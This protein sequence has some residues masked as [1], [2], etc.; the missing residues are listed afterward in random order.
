MCS[1]EN[2]SRTYAKIPLDRTLFID[3]LFF[4]LSQ[5]TVPLSAILKE[6][7]R[8]D[9]IA[10]LIADNLLLSR[11]RVENSSCVKTPASTRGC[12]TYDNLLLPCLSQLSRGKERGTRQTNAVRSDGRK[13]ER[14]L[15]YCWCWVATGYRPLQS[16][17]VLIGL[18]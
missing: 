17:N 10:S 16:A 1:C 14:A 5:E 9:L 11:S 3:S 15:G 8:A 2:I 7:V 6:K 13:T 18:L 12:R 4:A